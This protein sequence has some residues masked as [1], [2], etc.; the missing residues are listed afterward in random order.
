MK[1]TTSTY[2]SIIHTDNLEPRPK[3]EK[4]KSADR[5]V[6]TGMKGLMSDDDKH[7]IFMHQCL[8][9][10]SITKIWI[11]GAQ[12]YPMGSPDLY[13]LPERSIKYTPK[14]ILTSLKLKDRQCD[15][16]DSSNPDSKTNRCPSDI[17]TLDCHDQYVYA[18]ACFSNAFSVVTVKEHTNSSNNNDINS[19]SKLPK[20]YECKVYCG[21]HRD[22][23][24]E[25]KRQPWVVYDPKGSK[26]NLLYTDPAYF[27]RDGLL[28]RWSSKSLESVRTKMQPS[29][30]FGCDNVIGGKSCGKQI[31]VKILRETIYAAGDALEQVRERKIIFLY[32]RR[33]ACCTV[34]SIEHGRWNRIDY[35]SDCAASLPTKD[36]LIWIAYDIA[37]VSSGDTG[38]FHTSN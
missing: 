18:I 12:L 27:C 16:I 21:G 13:L 28:N 32:L 7:E 15:W 30:N 23:F 14:D 6:A 22:Q 36:K 35:C 1:T 5:W 29:N 38:S 34:K 9:A 10:R 25:H 8:C 19:N 26:P 4:C 11:K 37:D 2:E 3:C 17:L 33:G 20:F 31:F 24:E